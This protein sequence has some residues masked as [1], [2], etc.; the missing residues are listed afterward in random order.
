MDRL[1][2]GCERGEDAVGEI[3]G[4]RKFSTEQ[5]LIMAREDSDW[6]VETNICGHAY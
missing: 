3:D 4:W 6:G 5:I 2:H 1:V